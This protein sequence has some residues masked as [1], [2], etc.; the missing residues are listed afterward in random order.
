MYGTTLNYDCHFFI[1]GQNGTPS[2]RELSGVNSLDIGYQSAS[3]VTKPLGSVRGVTTVAG[4]I[5]QSVSF[6]RSLMYN[7]PV[8]D[9]TGASEVMK[10]SFNYNNNSSYGFKSGYLESYSVN[11][12]VVSIPKVNA[13]FTVYDEMKSGVNATGTTPTNIDIPSQGS[14]TATCDH[15]TT[16]RVLGFD[17]SLSINKIPYYTIGSETP[18]EVKH[19]NP[20]E[21]SAAVQIDVDDIFLASGFSFFKEGRSD[22]NLSFSVQGRNGATLQTLT[23]PNASLVSEQLSASADGSVR[24]T[25][26]YIGHS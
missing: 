15:S 11:C 14:I 20:I 12:A 22:K 23:V 3:N 16:N 19:I 1:S 2:A 8:L 13:S 26:N 7:D 17:Y 18:V 24:L 9:F 10:G 21:Y 25:L 4:A 5:K 6:S